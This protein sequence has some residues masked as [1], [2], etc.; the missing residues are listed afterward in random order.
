MD[1]KRRKKNSVD[2]GTEQLTPLTPT[3]P[4]LNDFVAL[5]HVLSSTSQALPFDTNDDTVAQV[6]SSDVAISSDGA[7]C[8][9]AAATSSSKTLADKTNI[10]SHVL[11][12]QQLRPDYEV[13]LSPHVESGIGLRFE[14]RNIATASNASCEIAIAG[15]FSRHPK[16]GSQLPAETSGMIVLGDSLIGVN[17]KDLSQNSFAE[18]ID[19]VR[20]VINESAQTNVPLKLKFQPIL[21]HQPP[22]P[23]CTEP[24]TVAAPSTPPVFTSEVGTSP[25]TPIVAGGPQTFDNLSDLGD[26]NENVEPSHTIH[27]EA[28]NDTNPTTMSQE[29][30]VPY[31]DYINA[32][33][34]TKTPVSSVKP[35]K[36]HCL[37]DAY[38]LMDI[39]NEAVLKNYSLQISIANDLTN[40]LIKYVQSNGLHT[41][42]Q[43][44]VFRY[45]GDKLTKKTITKGRTRIGNEYRVLEY[46]K[47]KNAKPSWQLIKFP[48]MDTDMVWVFPSDPQGHEELKKILMQNGFGGVLA[49]IAEREQNCVDHLTILNLSFVVTRKNTKLNFHLDYEPALQGHAWNVIVPLELVR[50]S[51]PELVLKPSV[52]S[53]LHQEAQY[54]KHTAIIYVLRYAI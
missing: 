16:S 2:G 41:F 11:L 23:I 37:Y 22:P 48:S 42:F 9:H 47:S 44:A 34:T 5:H 24:K 8:V 14:V 39:K 27:N 17:D 13:L 19:I 52:A 38:T 43:D 35:T 7:I 12:P 25:S 15:S 40:S 3:L 10:S 45:H 50:G 54:Q 1:I 32:S 29:V 53:T 18:I 28:A 20:N 46:G 36:S 26:F 21:V 30:M 51:G 4:S 6:H 49:A 31:D 33:A